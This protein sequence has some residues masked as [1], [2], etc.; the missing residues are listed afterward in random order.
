MKVQDVIS[1]L[2]DF[3]PRSSQESYD[4]CGLLVGDKNQEITS[5]LVC[6]D[7][8]E[9]VVND[10]IKKGCNL[11]VAHHPI[12]FKGLKSLTG[13]NYIERTILSCIRNGISLFAIHTNLDNYDGGVNYE[14]GKRIGLKNLQIL[15]PKAGVLLKLAVYIPLE[16]LETLNAA[17]F[18]SGAGKIG[19]YEECSY[20]SEGIGSF[21]PV[22]FANPKVGVLGILEK[23]AEVKVE[24]LVSSHRL[25]AVLNAM[26]SVHPYEEVAHDIIALENKNQTEGSGMIGELETEMEELEFLKQLKNSFHCGAIRH[27]S[28]LNKKIKKVAFCGGSG[29]FLLEKA[30]AANADIF[31]TGDFKYHEFF[32]AENEI[33]IADIGHYESEQF[34][35]N[36]IA[37]I[38]K[39]KFTTFA[40]QLTGINTNP[41]NYF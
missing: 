14:I 6:L 3:A 11:I 2:E 29:S 33:L 23:V 38:L 24:Y 22:E 35:S 40:V 16:N 15:A 37:D 20:Y 28:L 26:R 9:E 30:K 1:F 34:T 27:T 17:I 10:A 25:Q 31:I 32:D 18:A 13:K 41:I 7:C 5:V 21:K 39:K 19:N 8:T 36:L 12:I 4:N